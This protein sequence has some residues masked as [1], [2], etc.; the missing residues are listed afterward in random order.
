MCAFDL[1]VCVLYIGRNRETGRFF[2]LG[3]LKITFTKSLNPKTEGCE[4][5]WPVKENLS[6]RTP[7]GGTGEQIIGELLLTLGVYCQL[8]A[9][10]TFLQPA[11]RA[12]VTFRQG[13]LRAGLNVPE[14][15]KNALHPR[16]GRAAL[17]LATVLCLHIPYINHMNTNKCTI[18][19]WYLNFLT[20]ELNPSPQ[21]YLTRFFTGNFASWTVHFFN[22]CVKN[23][24]ATIIH[25]FY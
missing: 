14:K 18:V 12:S 16:E 7:W 9:L 25:L 6:L 10:V 2:F 23:E 20:P 5:H 3:A 4:S 8:Y 11:G 1:L 19:L 24:H 15:R 13:G 17:R 22:V 21:R